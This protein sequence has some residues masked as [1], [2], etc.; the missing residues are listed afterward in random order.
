MYLNGI[1][2]LKQWIA[3]SNGTKSIKQKKI[4]PKGNKKMFLLKK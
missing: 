2:L 4:L 3:C 1:I